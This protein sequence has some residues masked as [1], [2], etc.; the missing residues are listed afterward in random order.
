[1]GEMAEESFG[2]VSGAY[3]IDVVV[4]DSALLAAVQWH[5]G[6]AH[7][8][9][10]MEAG[11]AESALGW[12]VAP[13]YQ[14]TD[15]E[16]EFPRNQPNVAAVLFGLLAASPFALLIVVWRKSDVN[17]AKLRLSSSVDLAVVGGL[18]GGA[19]LVLVYLWQQNLVQLLVTLAAMPLVVLGTTRSSVL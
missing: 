7:F 16:G 1:M 17:L 12:G 13:D 11:V 4:G 15:I 5:L 14:R 3:R 18:V 19:V 6:T 9:F 2:S 8:K 10:N